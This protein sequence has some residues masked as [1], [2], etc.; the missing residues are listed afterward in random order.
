MGV[1]GQGDNFLD[2]SLFR[3]SV[4]RTANIALFF[5]GA[6]FL[7]ALAT[8]GL[9]TRVNRADLVDRARQGKLTVDEME[10]GTFTISSLA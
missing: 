10:R 1:E 8:L 4:F 7:S 6:A 2:L 3:N 9:A 5:Q